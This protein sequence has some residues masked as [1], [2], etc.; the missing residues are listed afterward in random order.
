MARAPRSSA[1]ACGAT[2]VGVTAA[3]AQAETRVHWVTFDC[4]YRST[5]SFGWVA[6]PGVTSIKVEMAGGAGGFARGDTGKGGKG[7]VIE[8]T[9]A[10]PEPIVFGDIGC[11]GDT[12]GREL[13]PGGAGGS[14]AGGVVEGAHGGAGS[15]FE[16]GSNVAPAAM[17]RF[18]AGGGGGGG[19]KGTGFGVNAGGDGGDAGARGAL[20]GSLG[21]FG[22]HGRLGGGAPGGSP[23]L[24]NTTCNAPFD[25]R[26]GS[27]G[28]TQSSPAAV[29]AVVAAA[30]K[31]DAVAEPVRSSS[32]CMTAPRSGPAAA[33]S[34]ARARSGAGEGRSRPAPSRGRTAATATSASPTP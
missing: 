24:G 25:V 11:S 12:G 6:P 29:V 3:P 13:M 5:G 28:R 30:S 21:E 1:L 26:Q 10:I 18:Y 15:F 23:E 27:P 20:K 22:D 9:L 7:A 34:P 32:T 16:A 19:G 4:H 33:D 31:A 2:L 8:A 17:A 14:G